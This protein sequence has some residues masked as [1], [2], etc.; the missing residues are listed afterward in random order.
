[1]RLISKK[2]AFLVLLT[3]IITFST[4]RS[5]DDEDPIEAPDSDDDGGPR[6]LD[7]MAIEGLSEDEVKNLRKNMQTKK[8]GAQT[9]RMMKLIIHSL[10]KNKDIFLRELI[11]NA[12]D[13]L[14]KIR[15]L[16]LTDDDQLAATDELSIKIRA[17][18]DN[19]ILH[20]TDTGVGMTEEHLEKYLGTIAKSGTADLFE[21]IEE[22]QGS[23]AVSDLIG[24]F[25]VGFYSSFL[26]ADRVM[27]TSKHNNGEQYI[28][29]SDA[30]DTFD[31]IKD[32]RGD[33]LL[34]GTTVSLFLKEE[35]ADFLQTS[36]LK[37]LIS[38]YSQFINFP[39][40]VWESD[41]VTEE[42]PLE[43]GDE[44]DAEED[45]LAEKEESD[46]D[47][48]DVEDGED[49]SE[50][51]KPKTKT[52]TKE[53]EDFK[54]Q[55]TVKPI[56][57][58]P[59]GEVTDEEYN[60]FY[61][62][63]SKQSTED[64]VAKTHFSAEGEIGFKAILYVP[65]TAAKDLYTDYG[66]KRATS[67]KLYVR[68]VFITDDFS[69]MM[70]KYLNWVIGVVDSDDLPLNV[71]REELQQEKLLKVIKKKLVRKSLDMLKKLDDDEFKNFWENFG[72][73][74]KLGVIEDASN[75]NRLAKLLRFSSSN[76]D[77]ELTGLE[78]YI[79][80]MKEKQEK[81]FF[82]GGNG[83]EEA[84]ASP[85]VERLLAKGY[86]VLYLAE[87]VD[88][89]AIQALPE[90]DG[91]RFQDA[92]KEGLGLDTSNKAKKQVDEWKA[93]FEPLM[94]WLKEKALKDKIMEAEITERLD[95]TP[96][97]LVASSFGWSGNMQRIMEAQAYKNRADSSQSFY[98][99][100]K[101]KFEINP[102]HPLVRQLNDMVKENED[103]E[104]ALNV[105]NLMFDSAVLQSGYDLA[106]KGEFANR[107]L[108]IMYQNLGI[109]S[110][111]EV[112]EE[113]AD[114]DEDDEEEEED[115][116]ADEMD[117]DDD[118]DDDDDFEDVEEFE[119]IEAAEGQLNQMS[120]EDEAAIRDTFAD[121]DHDE[122]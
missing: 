18:P 62:S 97:A 84:K 43:E 75:R 44:V 61:Q 35:A 110:S 121:G 105:A 122:L 100:Q 103:D 21:K 39:I 114:I 87:P 11:S 91:K 56:W 59:T 38:K 65:K 118:D 96:A 50:E 80:R 57:T 8:I 10:Y 116:D 72:T 40:Y 55:N 5:Q 89:Y 76:S 23:A 69:N 78:G 29:Q 104:N 106:D 63:I 98:A 117:A 48:A 27:V 2:W 47:E 70:P 13:A 93:E 82:V 34:R 115:E 32:P 66:S 88:E 113:A 99:K 3:L 95:Q 6:D 101:K 73:S 30:G 15:L 1:M 74:I 58:R 94:K 85:F 22:Q 111:A 79:E 119:D 12:S 107:I 45:D 26:V 24:Q 4:I 31:I 37:D 41:T 14:D 77:E 51:D 46:E 20:I 64:P 67:I 19:N 92:A 68:R 42:V 25:G 17:D 60:A 83:L 28:W 112:I 108:S 53:V 81:I 7:A 102:R 9:D 86:E 16:S 71:S 54:L 52:V 49:D 120:E 90:F 36:T 109:D 33:T